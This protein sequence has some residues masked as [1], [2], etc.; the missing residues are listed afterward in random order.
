MEQI[1]I[2]DQP[3]SCQITF[4]KIRSRRNSRILSKTAS[5]RE[6]IVDDERIYK[7]VRNHV[8]NCNKCDPVLVVKAYLDRRRNMHKFN[9][10]TSA[11]LV[12]LVLQYKKKF[13][14]VISNEIVR[15]FIWRS[16]HAG[17]LVKYEKIL[18]NM[19]I[20]SALNLIR[21][22]MKDWPLMF[23][24][25]HSK[26]QLIESL[27]EGGVL[28]SEQELNELVAVHEIHTQ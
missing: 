12:K 2:T 11:T 23:L 3:L 14:D 10:F 6:L 16:G 8:F 27:M 22:N 19:D 28:M 7:I 20:W 24:R 9:G 15:E 5:I 17:T 13:G 25:D 18:T 1:L 21:I 4:N 26:F